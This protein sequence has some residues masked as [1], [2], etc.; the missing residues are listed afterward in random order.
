[1]EVFQHAFG[2]EYIADLYVRGR[3][4]RQF[5]SECWR[6]SHGCHSEVE[7]EH[8]KKGKHSNWVN[9]LVFLIKGDKMSCEAHVD[10][11]KMILILKKI[12]NFRSRF[13]LENHM[14]SPNKEYESAKKLLEERS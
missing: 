9:E 2:V 5:R 6:S 14:I 4:G 13:R 12:V 3:S 10:K 8:A 1:M 7:R 11:R